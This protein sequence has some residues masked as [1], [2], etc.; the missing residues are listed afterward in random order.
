[1]SGSTKALEDLLRCCTVIHI[2]AQQFLYGRST[3]T[4]DEVPDDISEEGFWRHLW[5]VKDQAWRIYDILRDRL[6]ELPP[7]AMVSSRRLAYF[8]MSYGEKQAAHDE[9]MTELDLIPLLV[10]E[11]DRC[12]RILE[13]AYY[14]VERSSFVTELTY[15]LPDGVFPL[16]VTEAVN[17]MY[18][19]ALISFENG[20]LTSAIAMSGKVIETVLTALYAQITGGDADQE[21]LGADALINR[22]KNAGYPFKGTVREQMGIVKAH[23]NKAVH[24]S[25]ISP[26]TDEARGILSLARDVLRK[27]SASPL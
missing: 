13:D 11:S 27:S 6:Y 2:D 7:N 19:E 22:L 14:S 18:S 8:I 1:M 5:S 3:T 24:G 23:R 4:D 17:S 26:T 9:V 15:T 25:V 12:L 20:C 21:K 10:A 16:D